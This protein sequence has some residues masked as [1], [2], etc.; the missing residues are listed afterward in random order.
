MTRD[1]QHEPTLG[2]RL[3]GRDD[4]KEPDG[5]VTVDEV[6][7]PKSHSAYGHAETDTLANENL[8]KAPSTYPLPGK[9]NGITA[10]D[11]NL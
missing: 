1:E 3:S 10:S 11:T 2:E 8:E 7:N 4:P 5:L 9:H 6:D